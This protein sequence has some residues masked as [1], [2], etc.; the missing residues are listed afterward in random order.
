MDSVGRDLPRAP[1]IVLLIVDEH[2]RLAMTA[3]LLELAGFRVIPA[4]TLADGNARTRV[5]RPDV[6]VLDLVQS[7]RNNW[8]VMRELQSAAS[9]QDARLVLFA[10]DDQIVPQAVIDQCSAIVTRAIEPA[11]LVHVLHEVSA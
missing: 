7:P 5:V 3:L 11:A 6:V 1:H 4:A 8:E 10:D 9:T 2:E